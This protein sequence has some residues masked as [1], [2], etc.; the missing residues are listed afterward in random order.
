M[1]AST[2]E[3]VYAI[4]SI[5]G[6]LIIYHI[7]FVLLKKWSLK[8]KWF[9]PE[10]LNKHLYFPGLMLMC[11]LTVWIAL[12]FLEDRISIRTDKIVT[13]IIAISNILFAGFFLS[14]IITLFGK[15]ALHK[16]SEKER[17]DYSY[18]KART[19][20]QLVERIFHFLII[21]TVLSFILMT[22]DSVRRI[23][24]T[25]LASA[26][27]VGLI[28]GFAAQKSLGTLFA[29]I[30]IAI[31]QPIRIDDTVVVEKEFGTIGEI[32][33]TYVVVNTWDGRRLTVPISYF[34]EKPFENWTRITPEVIGKVY[35]HV[36]YT[37]PI[38]E[39]RKEFLRL[40]HA[41]HSW[42]K[43]SCNLIIS[44]T[45]ERA[46][47]IRGSMSARNSDD[48]YDLECYIR[49]QLITYIQ[50]KHPACLPKIRM[51]F[52]EKKTTSNLTS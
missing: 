36:D 12:S 24:S 34:L 26:G 15:I 16:Y 51:D 4:I 13:H 47:Q 10:L 30:Q 37:L 11:N 50:K 23:G 6:G 7:L 5:T 40:V 41:S 22:F 18:R 44:D 31:S 49:E 39:I 27:V 2:P 42:D 28:I 21:F 29:G 48:A 33:L 19:K 8:K 45:S 46:M 17:F 9:I 25:L 14:R 52:P 38:E 32:T 3:I 43:R 20:F 35:L 1:Y